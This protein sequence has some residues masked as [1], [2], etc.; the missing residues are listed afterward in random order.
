MKSINPTTKAYQRIGLPLPVLSGIK[1]IK[2]EATRG[3]RIITVSQGK[4]AVF[5]A[6]NLIDWQKIDLEVDKACLSVPD[7]L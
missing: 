3:N 1:G 6:V 4:L 7:Q 2:E 5:I